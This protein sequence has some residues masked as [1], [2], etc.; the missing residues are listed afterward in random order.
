MEIQTARCTIR[1]FEERDID[2][3]MVYRNDM[4]WM[5]YQGFKGLTRQEYLDRLLGECSLN[6]GLQLAVIC[7]K[8]NALIGDLYLKQ[9]DNVCWL[10]YSIC[11]ESA[12]QGYAYEA[13][14]AAAASLKEFGINCLKAEVNNKNSA[15]IALLKKLNFTCEDT[16][17]ED[18]IFTLYL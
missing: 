16:G 7:S 18:Q 2:A 4:D 3:F 1:H 13:V 17:G 15:S 10:G 9:E 12:R 5:K 8:S 6:N 11:R 14:T